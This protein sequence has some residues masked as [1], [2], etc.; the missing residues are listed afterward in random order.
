MKFRIFRVLWD[1]VCVFLR[2]GA[3]VTLVGEVRRQFKM[4]GLELERMR[5]EIHFGS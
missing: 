5:P 2:V 4:A 3:E 1:F